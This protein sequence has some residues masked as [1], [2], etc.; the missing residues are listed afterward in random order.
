[1][2]T[3]ERDEL[4]MVGDAE[5]SLQTA[6]WEGRLQLLAVYYWKCSGRFENQV[7]A[8]ARMQ[9]LV[10]MCLAIMFVMLYLGFQRWSRGHAIVNRME[11]RRKYWLRRKTLPIL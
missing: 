6:L 2:K 4:R 7:R 9:I 5:R 1:M 8:T 10:P 3:R 11:K